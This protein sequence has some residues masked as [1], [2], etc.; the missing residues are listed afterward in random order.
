MAVR[1]SRIEMW[2]GPEST[3]PELLREYRLSYEN[4]LSITRR[5]L[6]HLVEE[7]DHNGVCKRPLRL[8]QLA[9]RKSS[10][11]QRGIGAGAGVGVRSDGSGAAI[12]SH[13]LAWM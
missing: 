2:A 3:D 5:S 12:D 9:D 8:D 4:D 13:P 7:C 11:F 10:A 1:T 6:L